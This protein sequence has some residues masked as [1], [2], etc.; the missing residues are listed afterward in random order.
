[1]AAPSS[2]FGRLLLVFAL[3]P[4]A[5]LALLVWLGDRVGLGATLLLIVTTAVAG[6]WLA[7][8]EGLSVFRAVQKK[9]RAGQMPGRELLDGVIV[10]ASGLLLLTPGVLT[11]V[12]GFL[13]LLPPSRAALRALLQRRFEGWIGSGAVRVVRP[14]PSGAVGGAP[15]GPP[16]GAGRPVEEAEFED[17]TPR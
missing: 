1:M 12:V 5:E 16:P 4:V 8:R 13:G 15:F 10:L 6:S 7:H 3:V 2:V 11:D 9:L 14:G 17:V